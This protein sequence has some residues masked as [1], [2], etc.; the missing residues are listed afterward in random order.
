MKLQ[1]T[2]IKMTDWQTGEYGGWQESALQYESYIKIGID[3]RPKTTKGIWNMYKSKIGAAL[4]I[5]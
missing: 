1:N 2:K 4:C 5:S 3:V